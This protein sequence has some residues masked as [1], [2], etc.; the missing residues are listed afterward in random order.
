MSKR[1]RATYFTSK[2]CKRGHVAPRLVATGNCTACIPRQ[3]KIYYEKNKEK[4]LKYSRTRY[5]K[6]AEECRGATRKWQ[7]KN[8]EHGREKIKEWRARNPAL[9]ALQRKRYVERH[10]DRLR[11]SEARHRAQKKRACPKWANHF[12][13]QEAYHLARLRT[14]MLGFPWHVDHVVPLNSPRVCGLHVENN[15]QVI[16]GAENHKKRNHY[17]PGMA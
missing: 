15:L 13:I 7:A 11:A 1:T 17:W 12:F 3:R 14:K 6:H 2:P 5:E 4:W 16:P 8:R 9:R 10:P